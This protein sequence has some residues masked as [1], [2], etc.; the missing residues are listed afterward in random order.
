MNRI[1]FLFTTAFMILGILSGAL[2]EVSMR[3]PDMRIRPDRIYEQ[4]L[5]PDIGT[6]QAITRQ[7][8]TGE[9]AL[10]A[11]VAYYQVKHDYLAALW[12]ESNETRL[13]AFYVMYIVHISH[14]YGVVDNPAETLLGYIRDQLLSNCQYQAEWQGVIS[15]ALGLHW[16]A[17]R[18]ADGSHGWIEVDID[19]QWELF[20]STTNA[21]LSQSAEQ[22]A[23][24][25]AR[26]YRWFYTPILD[27]N[28][29]E[30]RRHYLD[31]HGYYD[32]LA[33]RQNMVNLGLSWRPVATEIVQP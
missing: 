17:V 3:P 22:L 24:G 30:A 10:T 16:R 6:L 20:D 28:Y 19:G 8:L 23:Q 4:R 2:L 11:I 15:T 29:P 27:V 32:V 33:L 12:N 31:S 1:G 25:V 5:R 14:P 18:F 7:A 13:R 21:W 9:Q 26:T